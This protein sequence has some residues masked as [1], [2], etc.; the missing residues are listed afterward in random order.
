MQKEILSRM[1]NCLQLLFVPGNKEEEQDARDIQRAY[2][3][4]LGVPGVSTN[5]CLPVSY[6]NLASTR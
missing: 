2:S 1:T 3:I 5:F 6:L 4:L